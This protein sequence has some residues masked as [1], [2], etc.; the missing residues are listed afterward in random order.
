MKIK[1]TSDYNDH[2]QIRPCG[3]VIEVDEKDGQT[4]I[5]AGHLQMHPNTPAKINPEMYT[6][7]CAPSP[8]S[9]DVSRTFTPQ[10]PYTT[11]NGPEPPENNKK[12]AKSSI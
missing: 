6:V 8:F 1:L 10:E 4:L 11:I 7:G 5:N 9:S 12:A 2:G 3:S